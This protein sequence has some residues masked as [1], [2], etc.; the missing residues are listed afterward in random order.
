MYKESSD[1]HKKIR[2]LYNQ[3]GYHK[4]TK[5][6]CNW[7]KKKKSLI[8]RE[9]LLTFLAGQHNNYLYHRFTRNARSN[10]CVNDD[11]Q[12]FTLNTSSNS[13]NNRF[14]IS[15]LPKNDSSDHISLCNNNNNNDETYKDAFVI[16]SL[17]DIH[18][19]PV[20]SRKRTISTMDI[21]MDTPNTNNKRSKFI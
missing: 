18:N 14:F 20:E 6:I 5:E 3:T 9:E 11:T 17:V 4:R 16:G 12:L 21:C 15:D 19:K 2:D 13:R 8:R 7:V 1:Y 10:W